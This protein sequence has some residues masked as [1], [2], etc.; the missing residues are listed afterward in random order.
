MSSL[1]PPIPPL[2]SISK[3]PY[4]TLNNPSRPVQSYRQKNHGLPFPLIFPPINIIPPACHPKLESLIHLIHYELDS[5]LEEQIQQAQSRAQ[6]E[7]QKHSMRRPISNTTSSTARED[8]EKVQAQC[9]NFHN[10]MHHYVQ[11]NQKAKE[12]KQSASKHKN[13]DNFTT[14]NGS[15]GTKKLDQATTKPKKI[16]SKQLENAAKINYQFCLG[17]TAC[18]Q[19]LNELMQCWLQTQTATEENGG[20][21]AMFEQGFLDSKTLCQ[22][23]RKNVERCAGNLVQRFFLEKN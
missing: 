3:P 16:S 22:K 19:S 2:T 15:P 21:P 8:I 17:K 1:Q 7:N 12:E 23:E 14:M 10:I 6:N 13:S 4:K 18:P 11:L 5:N 9:L 20:I